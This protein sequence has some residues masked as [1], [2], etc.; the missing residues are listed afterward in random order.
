MRQLQ[1]LLAI[2]LV[3]GNAPGAVAATESAEARCVRLENRIADLRLRLRLGYSARQG[4]IYRQ[5][6]AALE[7]E[8]RQACR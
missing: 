7:S 6:L 8:R 1:I 5:K 3:I 4:R 2:W